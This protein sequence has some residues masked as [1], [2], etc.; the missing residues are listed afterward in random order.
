MTRRW[1]S[2][3]VSAGQ[4][5]VAACSLLPREVETDCEDA[6]EVGDKDDG[7]EHAWSGCLS[8][9]RSAGSATISH[10]QQ[11]VYCQLIESFV[12]KPAFTNFDSVEGVGK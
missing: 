5:V 10:A 4:K 7:V 11:Q 1:Q 6:E 2:A 12:W 9:R 3:D 8:C